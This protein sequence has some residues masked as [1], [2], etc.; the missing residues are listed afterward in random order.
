M[1]ADVTL[2]YRTV[3]GDGNVE[4]FVGNDCLADIRNV[5]FAN[6]AETFVRSSSNELFLT[7]VAT[8]DCRYI[9]DGVTAEV[10][11]TGNAA[12]VCNA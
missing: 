6:H 2:T 3:D 5:D 8:G 7:P 10:M 11:R 4:D 12:M 1:F 9:L